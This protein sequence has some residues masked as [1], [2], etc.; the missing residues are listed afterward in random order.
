MTRMKRAGRAGRRLAAL[1][2]A[3]L[4]ALSGCSS[5]PVRTEDVDSPD[6]YM[7]FNAYVRGDLDEVFYA[8][9]PAEP[10]E[11]AQYR[12]RYACAPLGDPNYCI[13]LRTE[14]PSEEAYREETDRL[15]PALQWAEAGADEEFFVLGAPDD[16]SLLLDDVIQD[17]RDYTVLTVRA[18]DAAQTV[19]YI[20]LH[21]YDSS[22][23]RE[24]LREGAL[25]GRF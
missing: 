14:F 19:E 9:F 11:K 24:E 1:L 21:E 15:R 12:Y 3:L 23:H 2:A 25:Y 5:P 8:V 7:E 10:G 22:P 20:Y 18:D 17:G 16:L 6:R 4:F 13:W